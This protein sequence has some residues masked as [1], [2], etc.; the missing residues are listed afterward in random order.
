MNSIRN[1][2]KKRQEEGFSLVEMAIVLVIIGLI[3]SAIAVGRTT[4][5]K[6]EANKAFQQFINPWIQSTLSYYNN[7][8]SATATGDT[9]LAATNSGSST[10]DLLTTYQFAGGTLTYTSYTVTANTNKLVITYTKANVDLEADKELQGV[11]K[12]ALSTANALVYT[13]GAATTFTVEFIVP[14]KNQ[15][16][17]AT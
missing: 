14:A 4:L 1:A 6:G 7:V 10:K 9:I 16:S 15:N 5:K 12:N 3:V 13:E 2:L 8:G 17:S 11:L